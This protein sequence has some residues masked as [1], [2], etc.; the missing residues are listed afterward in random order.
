VA[1][2]G[3]EVGVERLGFELRER[4]RAHLFAS[5]IV[6]VIGGEHLRVAVANLVADEEDVGGVFVAGGEG[7]EVAVIPIDGGLVEDG[8]D[9]FGLC[10][11]GGEGAGEGDECEESEDTLHGWRLLGDAYDHS[12]AGGI[13]A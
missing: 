11:L 13:V 4:E 8:D 6:G 1:G 10:G 7:V 5:G 2:D 9:G 3:G 12:V